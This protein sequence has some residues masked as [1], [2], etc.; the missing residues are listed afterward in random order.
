MN[1]GETIRRLITEGLNDQLILLQVPT[2]INSIRWHRSK[3]KGPSVPKTATSVVALKVATGSGSLG[4]TIEQRGYTEIIMEALCKLNTEN[5]DA[6]Y[7]RLAS[8]NFKTNGRAFGRFGMCRY[9]T[10]TIE[11]HEKLMDFAED[12]KMT[13]L[14]EVAHALDHMIYGFSS[15]HGLNWQRIM[16]ALGRKPIRCGGH[17]KEVN[18][19][20]DTARN[21]KRKHKKILETWICDKCDLEEHVF[22]KRKHPANM[23]RHTKCGG[24]FQVKGQLIEEVKPVLGFV[25]VRG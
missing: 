20:L 25:M 13:F 4:R 23:Y 2:T 11:V 21:E 16:V 6:I 10:K 22:K 5:A 18:D 19:I 14:H 1:K 8:W 9:R 3:M 12:F 24:T 17:S 15:H 7:K